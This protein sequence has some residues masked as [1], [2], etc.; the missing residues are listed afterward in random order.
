M[1]LTP[2]S[3]SIIFACIVIVGVFAVSSVYETPAGQFRLPGTVTPLGS[4]EPVTSTCTPSEEICDGIDND[5]DKEID[6]NVCEINVPSFVDPLSISQESSGDLTP[7]LSATEE[8]AKDSSYIIKLRDDSVAEFYVKEKTIQE[9]DQN[10]LIHNTKTYRTNVIDKQNSL[11]TQIKELIPKAE[12][13]REFQN[14]FNG[15]SIHDLSEEEVKQLELLPEIERIYTDHEVSIKLM[16]SIPLINA[17]QVW[18]LDDPEGVKI[19]GEGKTIAI[20]DTGIDYTHPDLGGCFGSGCKV[21][22]GYDFVNDDEDPMD[23]QGHGTHVAA[24]AAGSG[25]LKG[26]A[27]DANL[28]AY[29]VLDQYGYGSDSDVIEAIERATDP[30]QDGNFSDHLDVISMSLSVKYYDFDDCYEDV[31]SSIAIDNAVDVGVVVVAAASNEYGYSTIGAP[32]CAKKAITVGASDKQDIIADFSSKGPTKDYRVKPDVVAPGVDICAAQWDSAWDY[33]KCLDYEHTAISGTSMATPHVSGAA[34]LILQAHPDWGPQEI[35]Y[36]LRNT[37][38]NLGY[39][40]LKEGWG[41]IDVFEAVQL[42]TPPPISILNTSG[43]FSGVINI[44]GTVY[45]DSFIDYKIE[46]GQGIEPSSWITLT[47]SLTIPINGILYEDW[48]TELIED[49]IYTLKLTVYS[50]GGNSEDRTLIVLTNNP[51]REYY[52][53]SCLECNM[54]AKLPGANIHLTQDLYSPVGCIQVDKDNISIDCHGHKISG[55]GEDFDSGILSYL[56]NT[57]NQNL[58]V[59]NCNIENFYNGIYSKYTDNSIFTNNRLQS[60]SY[61]L[62]LWMSS[63]TTLK[64]NYFNNNGNLNLLVY[65]SDQPSLLNHSI[66]TSNFVDGL[67]VHYFFDVRDVTIENLNS[68]HLQVSYGDNV[69]IINNNLIGDGILLYETNNTEIINNKIINVSA[70]SGIH[71]GYN[72]LL[73]GVNNRGYRIVNNSI[74]NS[75]VYGIVVRDYN[76]EDEYERLIANNSILN[77]R[78]EFTY[79]MFINGYREKIIGNIISSNSFSNAITGFFDEAHIEYNWI[80]GRLTMY[81]VG[82][83]PFNSVITHNSVFKTGGEAVYDTYEGEVVELSH[84]NQGNY[85]GRTEE[86]YFCEHG[87]QHPNCL[88]YN[89]DSTRE[90]AIDSC[91]YDQ[92]YPLG[93]WPASPVCEPFPCEN[94]QQIGDVNG[95]GTITEEDAESV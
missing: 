76:F 88:P 78:P 34:A 40:V 21:I 23:D 68:G 85:W 9:Y 83:R 5:C 61:G 57:H 36:A 26:V 65:G 31:G 8:E 45:T 74:V 51:E 44:S 19:T 7:I 37:A 50:N 30:D 13:K 10:L 69:S 2:I 42:E 58:K 22:D 18:D 38:I 20:I 11:K 14:V 28:Y 67:P 53:S 47:E 46:Y 49:S 29:K 87:N 64:S 48:N 3:Y 39:D 25:T 77:N 1:G 91:P 52:C 79:G 33:L 62:L 84:K 12:I 15:F 81:K 32:G 70:E 82:Q 16:D 95:D 72:T 75:R 73:N 4:I 94:G 43:F 60:N 89:W 24:T 6:E 41:R 71:L 55:N 92:S 35:K 66:D 63:N 56:P 59:N 80:E 86:P 90:D 17:D 54:F 93:E 27:P